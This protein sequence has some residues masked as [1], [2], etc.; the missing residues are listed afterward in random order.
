MLAVGLEPGGGRGEPLLADGGGHAG[1]AGAAAVRVEVLVHLV[2]DLVVGVRESPHGG[3]VLRR[4]PGPGAAPG[5]AFDSDI[6]RE[7]C[8]FGRA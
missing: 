2:E 5:I 7:I 6:L 8:Y 4:R 3:A 1:R